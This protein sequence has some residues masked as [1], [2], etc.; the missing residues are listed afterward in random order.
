MGKKI[1]IAPSSKVDDLLDERSLCGVT[2]NMKLADATKIAALV[3]GLDQIVDRGIARPILYVVARTIRADERHHPKSEGLGIDE[4]MGAL[5]RTAIRQDT[6]DVVAAKDI[7]H[8]LERI[9]RIGLLKCRVAHQGFAKIVAVK[10]WL[11]HD[12]IGLTMLCQRHVRT[13]ASS[14]QAH[15][16]LSRQRP[17]QRAARRIVYVSD[18]L[19]PAARAARDS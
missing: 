16:R 9:I 15:P 7:E 5:I 2:I 19:K 10:Q 11:K 13:A 1:E 6:G 17:R 4:L 14:R 12:Q 8:A 18:G 3:F